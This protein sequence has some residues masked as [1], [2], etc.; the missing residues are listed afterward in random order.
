MTFL[1]LHNQ[2]RTGPRETGVK[3]RF[4]HGR[5]K[6]CVSQDVMRALNWAIGERVN[7]AIGIGRALGSIMLT[8]ADPNEGYKIGPYGR[9]HAAVDFTIPDSVGVI[10][11]EEIEAALR[12]APDLIPYAVQNNTL[13]LTLR[14][15]PRIRVPAICIHEAA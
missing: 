6:I 12:C 7:I 10:G 2:N 4:T 14:Q 5:A 8:P 11:G 3:C 13:T 9:H 1:P 15:R